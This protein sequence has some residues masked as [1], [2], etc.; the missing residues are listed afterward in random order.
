[1]SER[2][3]TDNRVAR[4]FELELDGRLSGVVD[5]HER[6]GVLALTHVEVLPELR[7]TGVS[8]PFLDEVIERIA[9]DGHMIQP[10]CSYARAHFRDTPRFH[11]LLPARD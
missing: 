6:D 10:V 11:H 4:R 3:I 5:Y 2:K 8:A 9:A 7:G 1:M